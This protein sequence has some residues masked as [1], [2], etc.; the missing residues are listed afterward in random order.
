MTTRRGMLRSLLMALPVL[1]VAWLAIL[2]I[3]MRAGGE[4]PAAFV[5]FPPDGLIAS[6]S[7]DVSVTGASP[8]S[9]TL[10]SD[11]PDLVGRLY[12]AG[13]WLVLPAGLEACIPRFLRSDD[14]A[15][16]AGASG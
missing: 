1:V 16:T 4:A 9:L 8:I 3:V 14:P 7:D 15:R 2:A 12:D 6:L 10:Q 11:G 13:A 5:P